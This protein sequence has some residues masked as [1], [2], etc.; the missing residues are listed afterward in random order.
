MPRGRGGGNGGGISYGID[1]GHGESGLRAPGL[2]W[3]LPAAVLFRC[4]GVFPLVFPPRS[5]PT[6]VLPPVFPLACFSSR[7]SLSAFPLLCLPCAFPYAVSP[8]LFFPY[9][10][11]PSFVFSLSMFP[12]RCS[13]IVFSLSMFPLWCFLSGV[14]IWCFPSGV[15]PPVLLSHICL[16]A[17]PI[18]IFLFPCFPYFFPQAFGS[19]PLGITSLD[20]PLRP[21]PPPLTPPPGGRAGQGPV[22]YRIRTLG[23]YY[24]AAPFLFTVQEASIMN[25][26]NRYVETAGFCY[27][28]SERFECVGG[29][30]YTSFSRHPFLARSPSLSLSPLFLV[31]F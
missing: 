14:P 8:L 23:R 31:F 2:R 26:G 12:L 9:V 6:G 3:C 30:V 22:V 11:F 10:C 16:M 27:P 18:S 1:N 15:C 20:F 7:V 5:L 4:C 19:F 24:L 25:E 28:G 17:Y 13:S 21:P 29:C